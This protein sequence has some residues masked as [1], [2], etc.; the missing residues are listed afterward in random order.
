MIHREQQKLAPKQPIK[1]LLE[2]AVRAIDQ[3]EG[4][5]LKPLY[6]AAKSF[7]K[8]AKDVSCASRFVGQIS[9]DSPA[10]GYWSK[11]SLVCSRSEN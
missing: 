10:A 11:E 7:A 9:D 2:D 5:K 6:S 3:I 8:R 4:K 1:E